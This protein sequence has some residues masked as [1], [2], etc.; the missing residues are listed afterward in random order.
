MKI[1]IV[2]YGKM[3]KTIEKLALKEKIEIVCVIDKDTEK[4]DLS[5]ADVSINFSIP[6]AAKETILKSFDCEV[7]VVCG[8][9]GWLEDY[10]LIKKR[11]EEKNTAFIYSS[12]FS[13][14]VNIFFKINEYLTSLMNKYDS[15]FEISIEETHHIEKLDS[16]SGTAISLAN[17]I[18]EKSNSFKS[19]SKN[20][21]ANTIKMNSK[22]KKN[23]V[24]IHKISFE[25]D[26]EKINIQ[27]E[28]FSRESFAK[29][30]IIAA[31]WVKNKK[32]IFNMNDVLDF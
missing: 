17:Q 32:G 20:K 14:G 8:T 12:N 21:K 5:K 15:P 31:K 23:K 22:R 13:L 10:Q 30:S 24:G 27:H 9:T 3:G 18:I 29:G 16:P 4:G 7:P 26:F 1:A 2:G 28:A 19:W 11:C 25:S 6:S